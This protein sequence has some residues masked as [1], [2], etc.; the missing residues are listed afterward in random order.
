[1]V[2]KHI[3]LLDLKFHILLLILGDPSD[4]ENNFANSKVAFSKIRVGTID[5]T[6]PG[7]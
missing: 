4:V 3:T 6:Y 7:N 2:I 5:S 1:M